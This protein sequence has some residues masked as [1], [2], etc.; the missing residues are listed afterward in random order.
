M[1]HV[2]EVRELSKSYG[3]VNAVQNVSFVME[4]D[5]IYGLLGRNGA[6]KTTIMHLMTAQ[7]FP[8]SGS[9]R[10]FGEAPFENNRVLS[11]VCFIKE[12]QKYPDTFR[13]G[14]SLDDGASYLDLRLD[15]VLPCSKID[16][17]T[18]DSPLLRAHELNVI[19]SPGV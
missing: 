17:L 6:G 19:S 12:S 2:V 7:L 4:E 3:H 15:I 10:L 16:Y 8:T 9:I 11:Q 18:C 1:S 14:A 5:K 13:L